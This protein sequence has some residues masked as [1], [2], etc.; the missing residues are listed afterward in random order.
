M[1]Q[2]DYVKVLIPGE[3]P[4]AEVKEVISDTEFVGRI[5]NHVMPGGL[6]NYRLNDEVTFNYQNDGHEPYWRAQESLASTESI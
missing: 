2:G 4:W 1:K 6:H 5:D 3:R